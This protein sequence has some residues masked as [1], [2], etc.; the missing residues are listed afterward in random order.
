MIRYAI[1][2]LLS[3]Q[4]LSG[5]DLK[6]IISES[7]VFYW[8]GNNNQIYTALIRLHETGLVT[9]QVQQQESLPAKKIYSITQQ[10]RDELRRWVLSTAELPEVHNTFLI[11]L[12]CAEG[13]TSQEL[14]TLLGKYEGEIGLKLRMH[15]RV[16]QER[17]THL[18]PDRTRRQAFLWKKISEN[19]LSIYQNELD[20][21]R[22]MRVDLGAMAVEAENAENADHE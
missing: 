14:D 3:W 15:V 10:G 16:Q 17:S 18:V 2:G 5:Y 19:I 8:S 13:L 20:W 9:R 7:E 4:P 21:V 6:K 1:L 22:S 12:A 11:Q